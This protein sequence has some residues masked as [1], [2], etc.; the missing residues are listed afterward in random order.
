RR[1]A[2]FLGFFN[3]KNEIP[4]TIAEHSD[5]IAVL[6]AD[7]FDQRFVRRLRIVRPTQGDLGRSTMLVDAAALVRQRNFSPAGLVVN[8][9]SG[10]IHDGEPNALRS[11]ATEHL[12]RVDG[13][14]FHASGKSD[15][16]LGNVRV[17]NIFTVLWR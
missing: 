17:E 8:L 5:R 9:A 12:N 13:S 2:L 4:L 11:R 16:G 1:A 7:R 14:V 6:G 10:P 15:A 3:A